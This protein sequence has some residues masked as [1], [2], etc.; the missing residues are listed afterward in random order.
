GLRYRVDEPL[1]IQH[2]PVTS[3]TQLRDSVDERQARNPGHR[4]AQRRNVGQEV[5]VGQLPRANARYDKSKA[6]SSA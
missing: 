4:A 1:D 2:P 6:V 3:H 5:F